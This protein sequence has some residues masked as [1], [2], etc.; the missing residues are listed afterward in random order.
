MCPNP[1][2]VHTRCVKRSFKRACARALTQG[3]TMYR[4]RVLRAREIP[5]SLQC[6]R[7]S[8]PNRSPVRQAR[9]RGLRIF[10][11]NA[12][13]LGGGLYPELLTF[14]TDSRYDAAI[15]LE[16]KW[17]EN[18][19]V[20]T[21]PW[22]CLHS[23]CK[24]RKQAGILILI[25][26]RVTITTPF[27]PCPHVRVPLPGKDSRPIHLIGIYQKA[28]DQKATA[29]DQRHQVWQALDRCLSRVPVRD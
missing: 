3:T 14:L 5:P 17:Q 16:S 21:G 22:S 4:G 11:W 10:C 25:H 19:E 27:R 6:S 8:Q 15:V 23:G 20:T 24:T 12:G 9:H 26:H 18:M 7:P 28:Y 13:G 29:S 2:Q 1:N